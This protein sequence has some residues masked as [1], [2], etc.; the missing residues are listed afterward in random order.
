MTTSEWPEADPTLERA[1]KRLLRVYPSNYRDRHEQEIVT[2][3]LEMAQPGQS[4]PGRTEVWHLIGSGLRQRFRLP[5]GRPLLWVVAVLVLLIGGGFGAA[6]GSWA[7]ERT[8]ASVPDDAG[9]RALQTSL[10]AGTKSWTDAGTEAGTGSGAGSD[11]V[12]TNDGGTPWFGETGWATSTVSGFDGW[13]ADRAR[14]ELAA[15]GWRVGAIDHP[16]GKSTTMA[17][18]GTLVDLPMRNSR[19]RAE[20]D[21]VSIEVSGWLTE[22]QG[23]VNTELW[24]TGNASLLPLIVIGGLAGM[25]AGWLFVVAVARRLQRPGAARAAGALAVIAVLTLALP[26]VAFYGNVIRAFRYAGNNEPVF[27]V[28]S[29]LTPGPYWPFGPQ[30]L[31]LAL[32]AAGLVLGAGVLVAARLRPAA[33]A[34]T[35]IVTN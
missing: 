12:A 10:L 21:G 19:F 22:L 30:W 35:Q 20:R 5:A 18:D 1:Y 24:A 27:T 13:D 4:R 31:N 29:A 11:G 23:S 6:V 15:A 25:L 14:Q 3:L 34:G 2:T 28:H 32:L 26:A 17:E 33:T 16:S 8:F 7:S 9:I